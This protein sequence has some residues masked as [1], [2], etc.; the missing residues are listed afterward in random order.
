[1]NPMF[2]RFAASLGNT[3]AQP[4][5]WTQT[6]DA[7]GVSVAWARL[8][9]AEQLL[10]FARLVKVLGGR[11]STITAYQV[12][13]NLEIAYHFDL[14]GSTVTATVVLPEQ[15]AVIPSMTPVFLNADWNEREFM[16]LYDIEVT[17]H[18]NPRRLFI[19]ESIDPAVLQRFIPYSDL[20]NAASTK[21]LWE[22]IMTSR[23]E[24]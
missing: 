12:S 5:S 18:P 7:K 15:G 22:K 4:A 23:G 17:G 13:P 14:D 20:V 24:N 3:L 8:E 19:D 9:Q 6:T 2:Q 16:E 10:P 11:L 21:S 1:M